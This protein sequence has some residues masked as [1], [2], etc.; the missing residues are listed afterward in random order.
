VVLFHLVTR[1]PESF[2]I[3]KKNLLSVTIISITE[4]EKQQDQLIKDL[5]RCK[6]HPSDAG[7]SQE[8]VVVTFT[9]TGWHCKGYLQIPQH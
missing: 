6:Q 8:A 5:W 1:V 3:R 2:W 7:F 9:Q 4:W